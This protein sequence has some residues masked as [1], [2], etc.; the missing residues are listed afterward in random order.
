MGSKN[1]GHHNS[2]YKP[3]DNKVHVKEKEIEEFGNSDIKILAKAYKEY[4]KDGLTSKEVE[5]LNKMD[6]V[7][8][9]AEF[10]SITQNVALLVQNNGDTFTALGDRLP[11]T[12]SHHSQK[13]VR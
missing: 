2:G 10:A 6:K 11:K 13:K 3:T 1:D 8:E 4:S 7:F 5:S 9:G 12:H